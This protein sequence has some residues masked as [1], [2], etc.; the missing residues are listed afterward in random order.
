MKYLL[1]AILVF[2]SEVIAKPQSQDSFTMT[3]FSFEQ[4]WEH[5]RVVIFPDGITGLIIENDEAAARSF[6]IHNSE[7]IFLEV[8]EV[9]DRYQ[10]SK[11]EESYGLS[12]SE[13][14]DPNCK[15]LWS[16]SNLSVFSLQYAGKE[17]SVSYNHGCRGFP[18]E[19][20]LQALAKRVKNI[21]GLS[22][23]VGT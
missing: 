3:A 9:L 11:F 23:Y 7:D 21:L 13:G 12:E 14:I 1:L 5:Y 2:A 15:E 10:F 4:A 22:E 16:Q 6:K 19:S 20:E 8:I 17:K 18:R